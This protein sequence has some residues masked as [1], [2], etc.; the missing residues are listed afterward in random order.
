[1]YTRA[2]AYMLRPSQFDGPSVTPGICVIMDRGH[3]GLP[4]VFLHF[5]QMKFPNFATFRCVNLL[6]LSLKYLGPN[7]PDPSTTSYYRPT[8]S[9]DLSATARQGSLR[10]YNERRRLAINQSFIH[11]SLRLH[12]PTS[13]VR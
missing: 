4:I 7:Y 3:L 11:Y 10:E 9:R 1:M 12:M 5:S 13:V 8:P 2:L 6:H